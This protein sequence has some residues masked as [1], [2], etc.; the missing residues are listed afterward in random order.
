MT[1]KEMLG[2]LQLVWDNMGL[3]MQDR[4]VCGEMLVLLDNMYHLLHDDLQCPYPVRKYEINKG[5]VFDFL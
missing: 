4:E 1:E 5:G 3:Q 2:T